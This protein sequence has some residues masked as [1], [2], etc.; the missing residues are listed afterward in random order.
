LYRKRD[1][2]PIYESGTR[3]IMRE[4]RFTYM[5]AMEEERRE[6]EREQREIERRKQRM[7]EREQK[8]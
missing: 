8:H 1:K 6:R 7:K 3:D 4:D 5:V 2:L